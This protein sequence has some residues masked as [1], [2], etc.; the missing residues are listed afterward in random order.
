MLPMLTATVAC[1]GTVP[2]PVVS[3][4]RQVT[5]AMPAW[6]PT[7]PRKPG[8][9]SGAGFERSQSLEL[10]VTGSR[11]SA[12]TMLAEERARWLKSLAARFEEQVGGGDSASVIGLITRVSRSV[13]DEVL[14]GVET[15]DSKV[16]PTPRGYAVWTLV[17]QPVAASQAALLRRLQADSAQWTRLRALEAMRELQGEVRAYDLRRRREP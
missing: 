3:T 9:F 2:A 17:E 6:Y 8:V 10:A 11:L 4:P 1:R 5:N 12:A 16:L 13:V 7:P 15:R 14:E